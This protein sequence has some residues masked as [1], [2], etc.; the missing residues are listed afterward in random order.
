MIYLII[1]GCIA[2]LVFFIISFLNG[3]HDK[4]VTFN[5]L[6]QA[7]SWPMSLMELLGVLTKIIIQR[8]KQK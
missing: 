7:V 4:E 1:Y 3:Y 6:F 2:L 8:K 5:D